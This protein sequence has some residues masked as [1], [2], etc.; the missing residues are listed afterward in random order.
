MATWKCKECGAEKDAR[1]KPK[2]CEKCGAPQEA[3]EKKQQ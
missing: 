3:I 1:C 2:K